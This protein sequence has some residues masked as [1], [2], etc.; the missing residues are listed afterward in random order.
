MLRWENTPLSLV[1]LSPGTED[2]GG[3]EPAGRAAGEGGAKLFWVPLQRNAGIN[4]PLEPK[5]T[6]Q[7]VRALEGV[8]YG[9]LPF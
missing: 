5:H 8:T 2:T 6:S 1:V 3:K 9:A 7:Q 4:V